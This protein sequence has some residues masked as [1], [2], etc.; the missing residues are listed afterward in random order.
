MGDG[1]GRHGTGSE[2]AEAMERV[3]ALATS[4]TPVAL[5]FEAPIWTPRRAELTRIT[6]RRGGVETL[7]NRAWSAGAGSGAL[8]QP[9]H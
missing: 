1:E 7:Y 8:G 5:G 4:G 6:S 3:G 2:L 9:W